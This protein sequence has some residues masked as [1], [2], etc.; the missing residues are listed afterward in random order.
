MPRGLPTTVVGAVARAVL[1]LVVAAAGPARAQDRA[2]AQALFDEGKKLVDKGDFAAACPKFE[3]SLAAETKLG[4]RLALGA[5]YQKVG[6]TASAWAAFKDAAAMASRIGPAEAAREKYA[7]DQAAAL[8]KSLSRLVIA[9]TKPVPGLVVKRND[10]I[11]PEASLGVAVPVDP[12]SYRIRALA[13]DYEPFTQTVK[14]DKQPTTTVTVP[15]L[16]RIETSVTP[17]V[18]PP[19]TTPPVR[20]VEPPPVT[21]P[22]P[23]E[24]PESTPTLRYVGYGVGA[25]GVALVGVGVV[26]GLS[27]KSKWSDAQDMCT[28]STEPLQCTKDGVALH[29]DAVS[30]ATISTITTI[31]GV[32][33]IGGGVAMII[34]GKPE[35]RSVALRPMLGPN[36][37][38]VAVGG[39]F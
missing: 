17:P 9:V 7:I 16:K 22:A 35:R 15:E 39:G 10:Q 38:G 6:R 36:V 8:E 18:V 34:L 31:A 3:A 29:D 4:T 27:A 33:M 2:T 24:A 21:P 13:D 26:F 12:G 25:A 11:V 23:T 1:A 30:A 28:G 19:P 14:V 5:C 32:A 20:P 37:A